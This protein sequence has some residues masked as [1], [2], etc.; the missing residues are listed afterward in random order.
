M[1]WKAKFY[2]GDVLRRVMRL[3]PWFMRI[4]YRKHWLRGSSLLHPVPLG[5]GKGL[6]GI[7]E[8]FEVQKKGVSAKKGGCFVATEVFCRIIEGDI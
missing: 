3:V 1:E 7:Q 6:E 8:A 4:T 5:V 2:L